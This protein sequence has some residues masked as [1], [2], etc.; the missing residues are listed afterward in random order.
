[1]FAGVGAV[2][3]R[4]LVA[5][6]GEIAVRV[7]RACRELGVSPVAIYDEGDQDAAHV[8][9][10][11]DAYRIPAGTGL[12]YLDGDAIIAIAQRSGVEALHP[13]Y[14]FLAEN[15]AF[16]EACGEAGIV[17][18]GPSPAAIR[19]MGDKVA[20]REIA[21]AAGVPVVPGSDGPVSDV[22]EA[23][24]WASQYGYPVAV[25]AAGGGGGRGFRVARSPEELP[26]AFEGS[27]GEA[28]RFFRNPTVYL[29][30]YLDHPRH[31]EVQVFADG[32]GKVLSLGE[33]DC[34]IQRRHQK[35]IE[36]SPS[37]AVDETLRS[38]LGQASVQLARAVGYV[39]AGTVEFL[40]DGDGTFAFLE[41]NTRIQVEHTVTEL[42]TGIDLVREQILVAAGTPLSFGADDMEVRGHAIECRI[43]AEDPGR[44]FAPGP[45][46]LVGYQEPSGPGIRVDGSLVAGGSINPAY[47]SMIAK[48]VVWDRD[49]Q[50]A[51]TRMQRALA[52]FKIEGVP[53]TIP[54]HQAVFGHPAFRDGNA[55]TT[56]L[57][58]F[59]E[60]LAGLSPAPPNVPIAEREDHDSRLIDVEVNGRRLKVR[61]DGLPSS[62]Y[63]A[64]VRQSS[65][66]IRGRQSQTG[67]A[68]NNNGT[69]PDI[70]SPIQ[71]T[72]L[73]LPIAVGQA[74]NA[75]DVL[76]V[77]E[78]MKMENEIVAHRTGMIKALGV[79][80][81][82]SVKIGTLL[83]SIEETP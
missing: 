56:F 25:K 75:G 9:M 74:V 30:R 46:T 67:R 14:G 71:G 13:G 38:A 66:P 23:V 62:T 8:H 63:S 58:D 31:I 17:F 47:D 10:A 21:I 34:S 24:A 48:L 41:M 7:I 64:S 69:G 52:E 49:R 76:A 18:I 82:D 81:G 28:A 4:V 45:G 55:T 15:A 39:G 78:A 73:R 16:A 29:E 33:R 44:D 53:T 77:I 80:V 5:N 59:P 72:V 26:A 36:E 35:L 11:D 83:A 42:V 68:K 43:N 61:V 57:V 3:R 1:M 70:S 19:S 12:P 60:V 27:S 20:A 54:F 22:T 40:L 50:S 65:K 79:A 6:R 37:P 2:F 32:H 51:I